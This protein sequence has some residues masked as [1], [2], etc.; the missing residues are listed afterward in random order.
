V[1]ARYSNRCPVGCGR[2]LPHRFPGVSIAL[3]DALLLIADTDVDDDSNDDRDD[4]VW[5]SRAARAAMVGV[6]VVTSVVDVLCPRGAC[7]AA[8]ARAGVVQSSPRSSS[9]RWQRRRR[10]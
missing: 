6:V 1:A 7:A 3:R 2:E 9:W 5:C 4:E 8:R 10:R